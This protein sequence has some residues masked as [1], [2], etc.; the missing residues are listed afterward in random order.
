MIGPHVELRDQALDALLDIRRAQPVQPPVVAQV[1]ARGQPHVEAAG[2][3]QHTHQSL[4]VLWG[5]TDV[6]AVHQYL[7]LV[8]V[9]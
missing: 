7:A 6:H 3:R 2:V 9:E 1:L 4:G 5:G 8:G